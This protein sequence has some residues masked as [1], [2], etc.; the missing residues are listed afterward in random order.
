MNLAQCAQLEAFD[1]QIDHLIA[2]G[3]QRCGGFH[4]GL[5]GGRQRT[6][7]VGLPFFV[8]QAAGV[9]H[10]GGAVFRRQRPVADFLGGV[11]HGHRVFVGDDLEVA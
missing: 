1:H 11:V 2:L 7:A 3:H 4:Q 9:L 5:F 8:D 6:L 10:C